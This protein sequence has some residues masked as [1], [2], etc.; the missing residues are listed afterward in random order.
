[1]QQR[2]KGGLTRHFNYS[3]VMSTLSVFLVL[4]GGT[5]IAAKV[6]TDKIKNKAVTTK[7]I[8]NNAV[9]TGKINDGAVTE[10]KLEAGLIPAS[11][12]PSGPAGG[13]LTGTYP[14]P[15]IA[16]NAVTTAKLADNGVTN[17][18][19][20]DAAVN[21]AKVED[22]SLTNDDLAPNSVH[23]SELG[24]YESASDSTTVANGDAA[25]AVAPCPAGTRLV[26][27]GGF[28]TA[29]GLVWTLSIPFGNAW[30]VQFRNNSGAP[31]NITAIAT[32][33][34]A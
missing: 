23:A 30:I 8:A 31:Q 17:P 18:K 7:K 29:P 34:R 6:G 33:L 14:N 11:A 9:K 1:M 21:S 16:A 25:N 15:L 24:T 26:N 19:I 3:N 10:A 32:C 13:D 2:G 20:A 28:G 5:A 12:T 4:A 27:G 22:Q